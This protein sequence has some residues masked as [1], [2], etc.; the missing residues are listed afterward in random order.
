MT[1]KDH[2]KLLGIFFLVSGGLQAFGGILMALIYGGMGAA[3]MSTARKSEEQTMGGVFL[4]VGV[5]VGIIILAFA[6]F[7]LFVGWRLFK[8]K[9]GAR[10]LAII[11]SCIALL[12]IPLGTA[13]G[14]YG[15]WFLFG[16]QGKQFYAGGN[17]ANN[18]PPPP[19][20]TWQ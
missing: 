20:N 13:L 4:I 7:S 8:E 6:G 15:L 14:I 12:S 2:N 9:P 19:P 3:I 18:F 16:E 10:T 11:A 17:S 1:A 5:I